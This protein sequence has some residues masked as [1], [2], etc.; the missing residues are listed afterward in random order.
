[1]VTNYNVQVS[2]NYVIFPEKEYRKYRDRS[3]F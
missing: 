1:M 2:L 3:H